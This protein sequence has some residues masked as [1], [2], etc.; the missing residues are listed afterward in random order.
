M[1]HLEVRRRHLAPQLV[2]NVGLG[3]YSKLKRPC[4]LL[5]LVLVLKHQQQH[6]QIHQLPQHP[7]V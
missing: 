4:H 5:R 3:Q 2:N 1:P 6:L 7:V